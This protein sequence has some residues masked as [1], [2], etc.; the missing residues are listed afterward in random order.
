LYVEFAEIPNLERY[1]SIK[2]MVYFSTFVMATAV[3]IQIFRFFVRCQR[4]KIKIFY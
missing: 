4:L 2:N 3:E 1:C